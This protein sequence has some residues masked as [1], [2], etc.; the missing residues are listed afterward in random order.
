MASYLAAAVD[1]QLV[2][3]EAIK[4][5]KEW[6]KLAEM[7]QCALADLYNAIAKDHL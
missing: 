4:Q 2:E 5:N 7:A 3:H 1:E 6:L